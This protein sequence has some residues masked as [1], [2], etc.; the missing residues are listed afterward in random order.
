M[1]CRKAALFSTLSVFV[2]VVGCSGDDQEQDA[3]KKQGSEGAPCYP[4]DTCDKGLVCLSS[5]CVKLPDAGQP[6]LPTSD[7]EMMDSANDVMVNDAS[8]DAAKKCKTNTDCDDLLAC[9]TDICSIAGCT[10]VLIGAFCLIG[11]TCYAASTPHPSEPCKKCDPAQDAY[12]WSKYSCVVT[13]AGSSNGFLDGPALTSKFYN[14]SGIDVHISGEVYVADRQNS[15]VRVLAGGMV[16]TYAGSGSTPGFLDGPASTAVFNNPGDLAI[17]TAG[18][19]YVADTNN[20]RVRL[21]SGGVVST[22]AGSGTF[23][24]ADGPVTSAKFSWPSGIAVGSSGDVY[25]SD[26]V[27]YR[28]RVIS[29][30][31]VTTLAGSGNL[32]FLDG[33]AASAMFDS[34]A[35]IAVD[36]SGKVYVADAL[37]HR[38]R[39]IAGGQVSTLA[40]SG[41]TGISATGG[42]LDGPAS[43]AMFKTPG[44]VAVDSSGKVYVADSG[45]NRIR[46]ISNNIVSTLAG[47]GSAGFADGPVTTATFDYPHS[48]AV[49]SSGNVYVADSSNDR[50]RLIVP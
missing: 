42:F 44:D 18:N 6:D 16:T 8:W 47:S 3:G 12:A 21:I 34:P 10:N 9:T 29:A 35:G 17:D 19:V 46:V 39:L 24:F 43:S 30:G 27:N 23:G 31:Q 22:Y 4:N 38:I 5:T 49:D 14:P 40:G 13:I 32:G 15:R 28:I 26:P 7:L 1:A 2:V 48:I 25:V 11:N 36:S 50:I 37:N 33:P 20:N 41:P 45:N